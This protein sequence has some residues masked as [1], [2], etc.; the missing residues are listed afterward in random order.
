MYETFGISLD[1]LLDALY[2]K[3]VVVDW[4]SFYKEARN[5][6]MKHNGILSKLGAAISDVYGSQY[7]QVVLD[8]LEGFK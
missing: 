3:D 2:Q 7:C 6:G 4:I 1:E 5:A 8:R